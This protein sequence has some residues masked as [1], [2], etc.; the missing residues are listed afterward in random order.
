MG[1][2]KS[3]R[4]RCQFWQEFCSSAAISRSDRPHASVSVVVVDV[5]VVVVV[6]I[7]VDSILC[8]QKVVVMADWEAKGAEFEKKADKKLR[9]WAVWAVFCSKYDDAAELLGK[10]ANSYKL[11]DSCMLLCSVLFCGSFLSFLGFR[12]FSEFFLGFF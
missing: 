6:V 8:A 3:P 1:Y 9:G 5:V 12:T 4:K 2:E 7:F 11:A 10:A